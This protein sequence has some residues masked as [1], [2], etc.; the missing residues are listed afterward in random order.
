MLA[1]IETWLSTSTRDRVVRGDLTPAGGSLL[2]IML[3]VGTGGGVALIYHSTLHVVKQ[4]T[5]VMSS[6]EIIKNPEYRS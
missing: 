2:D 3:S 1:V 6:C 4:S 5:P